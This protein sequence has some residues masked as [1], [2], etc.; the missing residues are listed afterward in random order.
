MAVLTPGS[1]KNKISFYREAYSVGSSGEKVKTVTLI[2]KDVGAEF[3][4]IGTPSAGASEEEIQEQRTGKIKAEIRC[5]YFKGVKFEDVVYF[6]GGKFRIYSIQYEGRHEVLKIRAELRDDDTYFG[7]P[8]Q[9]Y[10]FIAPYNTLSVTHSRTSAEYQ[11]IENVPFPK[12]SNGNYLFDP[13]GSELSIVL[14]IG[15]GAVDGHTSQKFSS[16]RTMFP[17][18]HTYVDAIPVDGKIR[19]YTTAWYNMYPSNEMPYG[20]IEVAGKVLFEKSEAVPLLWPAWDQ[21]PFW[22]DGFGNKYYEVTTEYWPGRDDSFFDIPYGANAGKLFYRLTTIGP[23]TSYLSTLNNRDSENSV[24]RTAAGVIWAEYE[25]PMS[26]INCSLS[27][28]TDI[29]SRIFRQ[30]G[31]LSGRVSVSSQE[32]ILTSYSKEKTKTGNLPITDGAGGLRVGVINSVSVTLANGEEVVIDEA[33]V[34]LIDRFEVA[35]ESGAA[36]IAF[37]TDQSLNSEWAGGEITFNVDFSPNE[38]SNFQGGT[39]LHS[40]NTS[41]ALGVNLTY[42]LVI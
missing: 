33:D 22:L 28:P 23:L 39:G 4:Y 19:S 6:E 30:G 24:T 12:Q 7:M 5:R 14:I 25:H 31:Q 11:V 18:D 3:K 26:I 36:G 34:A 16:V 37:V 40:E 2:K 32:P 42:K 8:D 38:P 21:N 1:M 41:Y 35:P 20:R 27:F 9:E 17:F 29:T 10:N 15:D 13:D